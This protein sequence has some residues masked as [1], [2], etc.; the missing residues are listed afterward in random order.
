MYALQPVSERLALDG[1]HDQI[2]VFDVVQRADVRMFELLARSSSSRSNRN[3][4]CASRAKLAGRTL[5]VTLRSSRVSSAFPHFPHAARRCA[6]RLHTNRGVC[7]LK[8]FHV[9]KTTE[10]FRLVVEPRLS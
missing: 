7:S 3:L 4:N 10:D 9:R 1:L 2:I 5:T 8:H 6:L